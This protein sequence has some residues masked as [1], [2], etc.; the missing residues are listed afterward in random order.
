MDSI[1]PRLEDAGG[2]L[3]LTGTIK[4]TGTYSTIEKSAYESTWP[5][6]TLDVSEGTY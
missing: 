6:L 3:D 4:V 2:Q 5:G 1:K